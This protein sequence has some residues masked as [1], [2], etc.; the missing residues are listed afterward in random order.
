M[1]PAIVKH[2]RSFK[3]LFTPLATL[4]LGLLSLSSEAF[5]TQEDGF[6]YDLNYR[7]FEYYIPQGITGSVPLIVDLHG[8]SSSSESQKNKNYGHLK[9]LADREGIIVAWPRATG[10]PAAWNSGPCCLPATALNF[11]DKGYIEQVV[12]RMK[13]K[14]SVDDTRVY[15]FGMSNGASMAHRVGLQSSDT[16]AAVAAVSF[17]IIDNVTWR[18]PS[19]WYTERAVPQLEIHAT[20]DE[21]IRYEG[22]TISP[23]DS[24]TP[25][26]YVIG[27]YPVYI[28]SA[29]TGLNIWSEINQCS[30][31][32]VRINLPN[33][34]GGFSDAYADCA[35]DV[36]VELI[37]LAQGGH[38]IDES[39]QINGGLNTH[40]AQWEFVSQF[41]KPGHQSDRI[42]GGQKLHKNQWIESKNGVYRFTLKNNGNAVLRN[43]NTNQVLWH[44]NKANKGGTKLKL[45]ENGNLELW[46]DGYWTR[47]WFFW[48]WKEPQAIW[49]SNTSGSGEARLQV[50]DNGRI[51]IYR[52]NSLVWAKN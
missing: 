38:D 35:Q 3:K 41:Q 19:H 25:T 47:S 42:W 49:S 34:N 46:K 10:F 29:P 5:T 44:A 11:D 9:Y 14:A 4:I 8:F 15:I 36:K 48:V 37:T 16:F 6:W 22:C 51:E 18:I 52:S 12:A 43:K 17:Q 32:S 27:N 39:P 30:G 20:D 24:N 50:S 33:V 45:R 26:C 13:S 31:N 7:S 28:E 2:A 21:T 1:K 40:E 23:L